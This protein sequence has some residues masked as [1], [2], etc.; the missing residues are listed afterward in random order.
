M[1][2]ILYLSILQVARREKVNPLMSKKLQRF[3]NKHFIQKY[4]FSVRADVKMND[5]FDN[6]RSRSQKV[7]KK[8]HV[9]QSS[10]Y[11]VTQNR[12]SPSRSAL[13]S[14]PTPEYKS[15]AEERK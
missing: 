5:F 13:F 9:T 14:T 15:N 11:V 4:A 1:T 2:R 7:R 6:A 10:L 8:E 12:F 3:S